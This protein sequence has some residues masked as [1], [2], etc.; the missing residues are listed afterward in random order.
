MVPN[1]YR[2]IL[3]PNLEALPIIPCGWVRAWYTSVNG[4]RLHIR[5]GLW[6]GLPGY[7]NSLLLID[8]QKS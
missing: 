8:S 6:A 3:I 2:P 1:A 4:C 7:F 5:R